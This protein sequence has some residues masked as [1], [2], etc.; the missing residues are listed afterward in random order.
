MA[1]GEITND[2]FGGDALAT[3]SAMQ[4]APQAPQAPGGFST[5]APD[6]FGTI[7]NLGTAFFNS[8]AG[9]PT[10]HPGNYGAYPQF[11]GGPTQFRNNNILIYA[12][13]AIILLVVLYIFVKR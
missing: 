13:A 8:K 10:G 11:D 5:W 4:Q 1:W 2:P 3:N 7:G 9:Y 6:L 12:I